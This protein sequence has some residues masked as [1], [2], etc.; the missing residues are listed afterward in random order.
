[1][2]PERRSRV[3]ACVREIYALLYVE[4]FDDLV[5]RGAEGLQAQLEEK[6]DA[7]LSAI[8]LNLEALLERAQGTDV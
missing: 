1:M 8:L 6:S 2:S 5:V 3:I 4:A 7:Q